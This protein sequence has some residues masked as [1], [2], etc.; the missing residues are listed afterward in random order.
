IFAL[1]RRAAL[2]RTTG[3]AQSR[4]PRYAYAKRGIR[5]PL[6]GEWLQEARP[7]GRASL[8]RERS[9]QPM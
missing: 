4:L 9:E 8:E 3:D 5:V 7:A 2:R 6:T 1:K